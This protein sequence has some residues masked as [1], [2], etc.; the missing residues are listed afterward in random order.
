MTTP[1]RLLLL[2]TGAGRSGTST[3]AGTLHHLGQGLDPGAAA[4]QASA[5]ALS[6]PGPYL[7]ANKSNPKGFFESRWAVRFHKAITQRA[8]I[9]EFDSRPTALARVRAAIDDQDRT[10]L[11][12]FLARFD[13]R[14]QIVIK[15]P[16]TV[17]TQ[18]L[19]AECAEEAGRE[20]RY[21][22]ML[23]HPAE[24]VGSRVTYYGKGVEDERRHRYATF[25][26][27]RWIN[28]TLISERETR[29][30]DRA[31][32]RYADL[33]GDWRGVLT[34]LA[35]RWH[36][37]VDL[38][39]RG[40]ADVDDFIDP[41]LR[42]HDPTWDEWRIPGEL[43]AIA[44]QVWA[45]VDALAESGGTDPAASSILD[46]QAG[47]FSRL[48]TDAAAISHDATEEAR[49]DGHAAGVRDAH[50]AAEASLARAPELG[51]RELLGRLGVKVTDRVR[52][53]VRRTR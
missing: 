2:V 1:V 45:G 31:F 23:R 34:P 12:N 51:G 38:D 17:W 24:V 52:S 10:K 43:Q 16:R 37:A 6:V 5:P 27:A 3:M 35:R 33:L 18:Q 48:F 53:A 22:T 32:V 13:D 21:V 11:K 28:G 15:D 8:G 42:R 47:L 9:N 40:A 30:Q 41:S 14:P 29:G 50:A 39:G 49:R 46:Q 44:D 26:V 7:D 4:E 20:C 19:W 25:S 36:L